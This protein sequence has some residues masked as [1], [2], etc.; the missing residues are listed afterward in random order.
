MEISVKR[1]VAYR[2]LRVCCSRRPRQ[3]RRPHLY[4][5]ERDH[6]NHGTDRLLVSFSPADLCLLFADNLLLTNRFM[7]DF[8][9]PIF[10]AAGTFLLQKPAAAALKFPSSAYIYAIM[11]LLVRLRGGSPPSHSIQ[12]DFVAHKRN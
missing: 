11:G 7:P 6:D 3:R 5:I 12:A 4:C 2:T 8:G 10:H 1:H 9:R